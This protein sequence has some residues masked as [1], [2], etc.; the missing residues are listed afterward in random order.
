MLRVKDAQSFRGTGEWCDIGV[1]GYL[2]LRWAVVRYFRV[3]IINIDASGMR[4]V[5]KA[6]I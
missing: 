2:T 4:R 6:E 1:R 3:H 5:G